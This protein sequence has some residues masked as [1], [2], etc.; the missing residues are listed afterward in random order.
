MQ[1]TSWRSLLLA[2]SLSFL[3]IYATWWGRMIGDP[4][5]RTS[6][7]FMAFYS[8]GRVVQSHGFASLYQADLQQAYQQD[9]VGFPL[10]EG[11]VLLYNH[12]PYLA[13]LLALVT[14]P[15]YVAS[16]VRWASILLAVY[17]LGTYFLVRSLFAG[18]EKETRLAL[19]AGAITFLPV[20]I[21]LWH[22][23]DTA[24][25]YLGVVLWYVGLLKKRDWLV[26]IGLALVTVRPHLSIALALPLLF[27][28]Q[29]AWW[30][31]VL[32]I[33]SLAIVSV[34]LV[35]LSGALGLMNLL[36]L[37]SDAAW[38]G[39]KPQAMFDLLGLLLRVVP[40][41]SLEA[42]SKIG[43]LIYALGIVL[44]CLVWR[45]AQAIEGRLLGLSILIAVLTAPHLHL[46][47]LTILIFP[48]LFVAY[49]R[50]V[51]RRAPR[52]LLL[53]LG[54]SLLFVIGVLVDALYYIL[55]Y[56][57]MLALACLLLSTRTLQKAPT[58]AD[59]GK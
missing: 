50:M 26:A 59:P 18:E 42:A 31:S 7:D 6:S 58:A 2:G 57:V 25:L 52:W 44:I 19:F 41:L 3:I 55:P 29:A 53:P 8:A 37:S 47:D 51:A 16:F 35:G 45:R 12:M 49:E 36:L 21:S 48:L 4:R 38:F 30:R 17:L 46:H 10:A 32:V 5:E 15:D 39:I 33:A 1:I 24:F 40:S 9:V 54:A 11:Q 22:G 14:S 27:K 34:L 56:V 28:N 23:Q 13:P 43:W 20:F